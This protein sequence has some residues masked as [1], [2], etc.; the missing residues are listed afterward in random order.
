MAGQGRLFT[1]EEIEFLEQN[2]NKMHYKDISKILERHPKVIHRKL[3]S[4][5]LRPCGPNTL[6][7]E[8]EFEYL[9]NVLFFIDIL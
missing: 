8:E 2:Y 6:W 3:M 4:L 7:T 1:K 5:G 9:K